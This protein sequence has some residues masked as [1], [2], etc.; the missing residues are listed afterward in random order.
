MTF[1]EFVD[2]VNK[3]VGIREA[4][5]LSIFVEQKATAPINGVE[6]CQGSIGTIKS[7]LAKS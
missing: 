6:L 1:D 3:E 4:L 5:K 7:S 2:D